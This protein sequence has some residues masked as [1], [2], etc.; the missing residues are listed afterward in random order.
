L[1]GIFWLKN[2]NRSFAL[3]RMTIPFWNSK[4][5]ALA[6]SDDT[7][8]GVA[9]GQDDSAVIDLAGWGTGWI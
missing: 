8:Y 3:L 6:W 7:A 5:G 4:L 9:A 2:K 1:A